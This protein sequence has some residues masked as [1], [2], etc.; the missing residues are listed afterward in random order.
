MLN[1]TGVNNINRF[2]HVSQNIMSVNDFVPSD[3]LCRQQYHLLIWAGASRRSKDRLSAQEKTFYT[4]KKT[5]IIC[6]NK[7]PYAR[8]SH[9]K[10]ISVSHKA[11]R[12]EL[13]CV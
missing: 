13:N 2:R 7:S 11:P 12:C 5:A 6:L 3:N 8:S 4:K 10:H 1:I 9:H